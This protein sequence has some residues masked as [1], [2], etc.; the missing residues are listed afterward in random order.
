VRES[1]GARGPQRLCVVEPVDT[2]LSRRRRRRR[3]GDAAGQRYAE[4]VQQRVCEQR[5][6]AVSLADRQRQL[7]QHRAPRLQLRLQQRSRLTTG[8]PGLSFYAYFTHR[9]RPDSTEMFRRVALA[10]AVCK[11]FSLPQ[12]NTVLYKNMFVNRCLFRYI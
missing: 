9:A 3:V 4:A 7:L 2:Q 1:G 5:R 10:S 11:V 8:L 6:S 12:L